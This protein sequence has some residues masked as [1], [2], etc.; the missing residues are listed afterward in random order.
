MLSKSNKVS[1]AFIFLHEI[2]VGVK[3]KICVIK[4]SKKH[5]TKLLS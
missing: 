4:R 2:Q 1:S 5:E 3:N